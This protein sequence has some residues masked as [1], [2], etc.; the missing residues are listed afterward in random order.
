MVRTKEELIAATNAWLEVAENDIRKHALAFMEATNI[1]VETLA[2]ILDVD[3]DLVEDILEGNAD[4]PM[5]VFAKMLIAT[6]HAIVL[7]PVEELAKKAPRM[8]GMPT[9]QEETPTRNRPARPEASIGTRTPQPRD[10]F[11]R[12]VSTNN[13]RQ[14]SEMPRPMDFPNPSPN[15]GFP[16]PNPNGQ[17]PPPEEFMRNFGNPFGQQEVPD[18]PRPTRQRRAQT[19]AS[20]E[21]DLAVK[22]ARALRANPELTNLLRSL[23]EE[24]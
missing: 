23:A 10:R 12:F 3:V 17:L 14:N 22:L 24:D 18:A 6:N 9:P 21:D 5:S 2:D 15:M 13:E 1:D 19:A 8:Q 4:I 16:M 20:T 11:G 7:M